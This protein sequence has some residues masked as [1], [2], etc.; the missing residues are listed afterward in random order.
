[1]KGLAGAA[2]GTGAIERRVVAGW[3]RGH[4]PGVEQTDVQD[5][6]VG[7]GRA[8]TEGI[9]E[10]PRDGRKIGR[11]PKTFSPVKPWRE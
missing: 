7:S 11:V 5:E 9:L 6:V 2:G 8:K 4:P 3:T 10:Q 1:M